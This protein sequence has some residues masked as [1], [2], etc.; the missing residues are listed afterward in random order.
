MIIFLTV[1]S[2]PSAWSSELG[3]ENIGDKAINAVALAYPVQMLIIAFGVG[4]G[5]GINALLSRTLGE[6]NKEK[7]NIIAGNAIAIS[8]IYFAVTAL[9]GIFVAK[10][11]ILSQAREPV[12]VQ[13]AGLPASSDF[14]KADCWCVFNCRCICA[15][16]H[17]VTAYYHLA[18]PLSDN[19]AAACIHI[20]TAAI[21]KHI[22]M[23]SSSDSRWNCMYCS[24]P[25]FKKSLQS[26]KYG[27]QCL[28]LRKFMPFCSNRQFYNHF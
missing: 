22:C 2:F 13:I 7:A 25:S 8:L 1:I 26:A 21:R 24:S 17:P 14:C 5:V 11:F 28:T 15:A 9:F 16:L 20:F 23:G 3:I 6:G 4:T 19:R 18:S 12:I 10:A 27:A